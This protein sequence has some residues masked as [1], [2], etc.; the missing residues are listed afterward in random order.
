MAKFRKRPVEVEATQWLRHGDH[1]KVTAIPNWH[2]KHGY[3]PFEGW[4]ET[5]EGGHIVTPGDWIITG[6]HGEHYACKPDIFMATYEPV[7]Q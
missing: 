2:Q 6:V 3:S 1:P 5:L 4:I 7:E